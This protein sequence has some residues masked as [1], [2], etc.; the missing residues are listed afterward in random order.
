M[1]FYLISTELRKPYEPVTC[2]VISQCQNSVSDELVVVS[3]SPP[4]SREIYGTA[5]DVEML[6]LATREQSRS[7]MRGDFPLTV[8]VCELPVA[9]YATYDSL[10]ILDWGEIHQSE[11]A[12]M[13]ALRRWKRD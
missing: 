3:V 8:Y 13:A 12:A 10:R 2:A 7:I 6:V 11:E 5:R 9:E 4:I 1:V